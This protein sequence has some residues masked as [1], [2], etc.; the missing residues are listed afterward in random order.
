MR[1]ST[2]IALS[3]M[4][5]AFASA[6]QVL[7]GRMLHGDKGDSKSKTY[8]EVFNQAKDSH[9]SPPTFEGGYQLG[10]ILGF[11]TTGAFMIFAVSTLIYD[12]R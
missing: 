1:V 5:V 8:T 12:E 4:L 9:A 10:L 11:I 2:L 3:S 6:Q 7:E